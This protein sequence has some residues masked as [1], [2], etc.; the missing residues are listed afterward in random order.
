MKITK[1]IE[2]L[3]EV[4]AEHGDLQVL[5]VEGY[6]DWGE[7]PV[8]KGKCEVCE[9]EDWQKRKIELGIEKQ[10]LMLNC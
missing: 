7:E 9:L 1:L 6:Y 5:C 10:Y 2:Y 3:E 4:K 8:N